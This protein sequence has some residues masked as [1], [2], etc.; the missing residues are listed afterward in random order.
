MSTRRT[1]K[2][3]LIMIADADE[4]E[5]GLMK[6]ILKLV[7]FEVIEARD[8]GQVAKLAKVQSPDLLVIDLA[9]SPLG[10]A[11]AVQRIRRELGL[12]DLP[13]VAVSKEE[14]RLRSHRSHS[15]TAFLPKPIEYEQFYTLID[16][17]LPG[18]MSSL[19]RSNYLVF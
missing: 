2:V 15:S 9:V 19:A 1:G 6:A 18:Q 5:R 10:A 17:F 7:G 12:P 13:I 8:P 3:P 11:G 16:R 14:S 4:E